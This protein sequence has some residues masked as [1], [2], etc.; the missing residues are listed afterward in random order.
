MLFFR[1]LFSHQ[2]LRYEDQKYNLDLSYISPR[3]IAMALP[4][5]GFKQLYRNKIEDVAR[6]LHERHGENFLV[7]NASGSEYDP[8]YFS[9]RLLK[10]AWQN[11][12]PQ[13]FLEFLQLLVVLMEFFLKDPDSVLVIHCNAGKGRTGSIICGLLFLS[14]LF[15]SIVQCNGRFLAKRGVCVTRRGQIRYLGYFRSFLESPQSQ[16]NFHKMGLESVTVKAANGQLLDAHF[17]V[18]VLD[19]KDRVL[20]EVKFRITRNKLRMCEQKFELGKEHFRVQI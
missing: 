5:T 16:L 1:K 20:Q 10:I 13:V 6:F 9:G 11:F 8:E 2:K 4:S 14:G 3:L 15:Q 17:Q 19:F 18:L 12:N 7:V